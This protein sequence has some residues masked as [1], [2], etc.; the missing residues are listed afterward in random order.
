MEDPGLIAVSAGWGKIPGEMAMVA[1]TKTLS[2]LALAGLLATM[3]VLAQAASW[4]TV[5]PEGWTVGRTACVDGDGYARMTRARMVFEHPGRV[6]RAHDFENSPVGVPRP[7]TTAPLDY[8][9]ATLAGCLLLARPADGAELALDRAGALVSPLLGV[10][11]LG[12][13]FFWTGRDHRGVGRWP[14][15]ILAALSPI[16]AHGFALGRPDHQ[17]LQLFLVAVALAAEETLWRQRQPSRSWALAGGIAWG[18]ALWVSLYEPAVLLIGALAIGAVFHRE[19]LQRRERLWELA[20]GAGVLG[21]A[22]WVEGGWWLPATALPGREDGGV[23]PGLFVAWTRQVGELG[24]LPPWS[25]LILRWVGVGTLAA[26]VLLGWGIWRQRGGGDNDGASRVAATYW[27]GLLL[28]TWALTCWQARWGYFF[29]LVAAISLPAQTASLLTGR[30]R[31]VLSLAGAAWLVGLTPILGEFAGRVDRALYPREEDHV[32]AAEAVAL[33]QVADFTRCAAKAD[34]SVSA[35][36][37]GGILAP[38]WLSPALA[39]RSGQPAVAGSSHESLPGTVDAARF[40]LLSARDPAA[41]ALLR[42]HRVRWVVVDDP[43]RVLP[44]A[45]DLLG[46]TSPPPDALGSVLARFPPR[47]PRGLRLAYANLFFKVYAVEP[48]VYVADP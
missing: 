22:L 46:D 10:A 24:S 37:N 45:A 31:W 23:G 13:L 5:F 18:L 17:S 41:L 19:T 38:W 2:T 25:G 48:V 35:G 20:A 12:W 29:A 26:P 40:F 4:R 39:Y 14:A 6:V 33:V 42:A 43:D 3:A 28:G 8:L 16:L 30:P 11:T 21:L 1:T 34:P 44:M 36:G 32:Q 47:A 7:H 9:I 15:L 27:L